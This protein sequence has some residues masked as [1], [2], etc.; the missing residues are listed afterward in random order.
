MGKLDCLADDP[1]LGRLSFQSRASPRVE[2]P[3]AKQHEQFS[4]VHQFTVRHMHD[5]VGGISN[6]GDGGTNIR[7]RSVALLTL[8]GCLLE[9]QGASKCA[10]HPPYLQGIRFNRHPPDILYQAD[11][12]A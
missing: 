12:I 8:S 10:E 5:V 4:N 6:S 11:P 1:E 7:L 9:G 2:M 3:P